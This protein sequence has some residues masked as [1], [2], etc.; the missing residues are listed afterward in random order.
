MTTVLFC[1]AWCGYWGG[2]EQNVADSAAGLRAR[3]MR[4]VLAA[5]GAAR[6]AAQYATHFDASYGCSEFGNDAGMPFAEIIT[7][8]N[9]AVIYLHKVPALTQIRP[10]ATGRR[11]VMMVHDHDLCCPRRHKYFLWTGQVC[12]WPFTPWRC[13]CDGACMERR[14]GRIQYVSLRE[15]YAT[16]QCAR[17][18]DGMLVG[19]HCM[20]DE[21]EQNGIPSTRIT[22][23][24]P[25]IRLGAPTVRPLPM[26]PE[27]LY[28]GQLIRG[29]G[30][31]MA[32]RAIRR[33]PEARLHIIGVGNAEATLRAQAHRLGLA[34]RVVFHGWVDH[35]QLS[36]AYANARVVIVPSRWPEPFG[37][38]GIEAMRHARPVVGFAVGGIPDWL[39]DGVNGFLAPAQ[40]VTTFAEAIEL[41]LRDDALAA[42]LGEQGRMI[43]QARYGYAEYIT[44]LAEFLSP[45]P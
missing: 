1:N 45:Q 43:A 8:E 5:G 3:G 39:Q 20:R 2:V 37:M 40:D 4:C 30:V 13:W 34:Q 41:L 31:D 28:V 24:P 22:L 19:S 11:M 16:L 36:E 14:D 27:V 25:L 35:A 38:V 32:L 33:V 42:G 12:H 17:T 15:K 44:Q 9:P 10:L 26:A 6:N 23:L 18:L 29:K 7:R 21:L